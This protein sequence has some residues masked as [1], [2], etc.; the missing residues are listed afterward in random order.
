[1]AQQLSNS[2]K[3]LTLHNIIKHTAKELDVDTKK[4]KSFVLKKAGI[5][6]KSQGEM[7]FIEH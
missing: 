5:T 4:V 3:S 1:M 7:A 2:K 6:V